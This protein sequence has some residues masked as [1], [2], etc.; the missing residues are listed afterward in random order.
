LN[1]HQTTRISLGR[2][3]NGTVTFEGLQFQL[4]ELLARLEDFLNGQVGLHVLSAK[5]LQRP[6]FARGDVVVDNITTPGVATLQQW[7]GT[8]LVPFNIGGTS[9]SSVSESVE[10]NATED[11]P[12]LALVTST[13]KV[14]DSN[15]IV[16]FNR[17]VGISLVPVSNGNIATLVVSGE[18][19]SS[20]WTWTPNLK[21]FLN[22]T[23]L[24]IIP[25]ATGFSQMIAVTRNDHT[26]IIRMQPPI[27]L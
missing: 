23:A 17:V 16:H 3:L 26:I 24:S 21:L 13:G 15:N 4:G 27:L 2:N 14:A 20:F 9:V 6:S 19:S 12:R 7:D 25:P 22:G 5:T 10:V 18:V 11:I 1:K 8:K